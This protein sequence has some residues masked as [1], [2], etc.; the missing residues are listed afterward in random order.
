MVRLSDGMGAS[1]SAT[2]CLISKTLV[3]TS[4][5]VAMKF[6]GNKLVKVKPY[7]FCL[8]L[9]KDVNQSERIPIADFRY[10]K[11]FEDIYRRIEKAKNGDTNFDIY[12]LRK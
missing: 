8:Q 12:K 9:F 1:G 4:A 11:K 10:P 6:N 5:H 3:L 7:E 2:G